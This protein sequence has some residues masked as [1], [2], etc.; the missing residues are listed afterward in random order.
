MIYKAY[1]RYYP[2]TTLSNN[3]DI[4]AVDSEVISGLA[5]AIHKN[6]F[7]VL[8]GHDVRFCPMEDVWDLIAMCKDAKLQ[9]EMKEIV[10]DI[11]L[12]DRGSREYAIFKG[13][14]E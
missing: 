4:F 6:H 13:D 8:R 11:I 9:A 2:Q 3:S 12:Y 1:S 10:E 5:F 7:F 14:K